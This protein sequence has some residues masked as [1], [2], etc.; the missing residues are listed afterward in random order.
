MRDRIA[1][2]FAQNLARVRNLVDIYGNHLAGQG[3]GRRSYAKTDV[4]LATVAPA[5]KFTLGELS[6]YRGKSLCEKGP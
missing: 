4:L 2:R 5:A 6:T 1:E 3:R